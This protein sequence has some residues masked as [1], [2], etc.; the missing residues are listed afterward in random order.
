MNLTTD[1]KQ[2]IGIISEAIVGLLALYN[3]IAPQFELPNLVIGNETIT[4]IV[5]AGVVIAIACYNAWKNRNFTYAAKLAQLV[6]EAIKEGVLAPEAVEE[7]LDEAQEDYNNI[8]NME[9]D[10]I[11][12]E[13]EAELEKEAEEIVNSL[14]ED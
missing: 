7:L 4:A 12:A 9:N 1:Q 13:I 8:V 14:P 6:L 10:R 5:T 2:L 3:L 11:N